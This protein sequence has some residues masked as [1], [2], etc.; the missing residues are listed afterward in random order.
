MSSLI[1]SRVIKTNLKK[2]K[3]LQFKF[4]NST[5]CT[6][7][8][9]ELVK[10]YAENVSYKHSSYNLNDWTSNS[11]INNNK[12]LNISRFGDIIQIIESKQI[13]NLNQFKDDFS[14][15]YS[16]IKILKH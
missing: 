5:D 13:M 3:V 1:F 4:K 15:I 14:N 7:H 12:P 9:N 8:Y 2:Y 6:A 11:F 10:K 16:E